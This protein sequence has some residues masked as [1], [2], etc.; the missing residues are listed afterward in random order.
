MPARR[1]F[2]A[3]GGARH[4][5][6]AQRIADA[7]LAWRGSPVLLK[8][9]SIAYAEPG[10]SPKDWRGRDFL[11]ELRRLGA[12]VRPAAATVRPGEVLVQAIFLRPRAYTGRIKL[13]PAE[14]T[15]AQRLARQAD[16]AVVVS[17]GSPF[18]LAD[19]PSRSGLC[20]FSHIAASQ[21]AAAQA[22]L[23]RIPVGGRMPAGL[24]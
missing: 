1:L 24:Q 7:C 9:R 15:A 6:A 23:G 21:R 4:A 11:S 2:P 10:A 5:A 3:L 20:A 8:G 17:F 22:L 18:V 13:E 12:S 14:I 16:V 19:F